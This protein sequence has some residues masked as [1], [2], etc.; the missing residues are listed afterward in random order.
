MAAIPSALP[1]TNRYFN[2]LREAWIRP[3]KQTCTAKDVAR[4]ASRVDISTV[5]RSSE[6]EGSGETK[7][8]KKKNKSKKKTSSS[9]SSNES[10]AAAI[11]SIV[12]K[13]SSFFDIN[14]EPA[15]REAQEIAGEL[16]ATNPDMSAWVS[17]LLN[18]LGGDEN[19]VVRVLKC[20]HQNILFIAIFEL[21]SGV[22]KDV[23]IKDSRDENSWRIKI[24]AEPGRVQVTHQR[25]EDFVK[26]PGQLMW[27]VSM[28]FDDTM[29]ELCAASLRLT[30]LTV[31]K[32]A[33]ASDRRVLSQKLSRG[34]LI[35]K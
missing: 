15:I 14:P 25:Q 9:S 26:M 17:T 19:S 10:R 22:L 32:E 5:N 30:G 31:E 35:I 16:E 1:N 34:K 7:Q 13:L 6:G 23:D 33:K 4:L 3:L 29:T 12:R 28:T 24:T 2:E 18:C 21:K 11:L 8:T 27:E 20:C